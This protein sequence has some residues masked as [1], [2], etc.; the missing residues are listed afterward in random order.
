MYRTA[1]GGTTWKKMN[2]DEY[3][4]SPKGPYYFSQIR[5]DPNNDQNIFVTQDGYRHSTDGG[6]T[7]DALRVFPRMF[8]DFRTLWIDPENSDRMIAGSDGGIAI[9]YDGGATSDH[10]ANIPVGEI[11]MISVDMEEPYNLY[12][13]L[14]DHENWRVPRTPG[15]D[16][17]RSGT[18]WP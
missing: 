3:K 10:F 9:W 13:G 16:G 18:G 2:A 14:Q 15:W 8:G 12:A 4:V 7:W 6:K 17:S 11:Y 5:V 1:D